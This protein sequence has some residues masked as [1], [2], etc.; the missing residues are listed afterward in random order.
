[1]WLELLYPDRCLSCDAFTAGP[2]F[3]P[4]CALSLYPTA[5]FA[6]KW[7]WL[8]PQG[9]SFIYTAAAL[10]AVLFVLWALSKPFPLPS[11]VTALALWG[12]A[13]F[14]GLLMCRSCVHRSPSRSACSSWRR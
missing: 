13:T 8:S 1:M 9:K 5:P 10:S 3:C 7:D 14:L 11:T 4:R 6:D 2:G 12:G